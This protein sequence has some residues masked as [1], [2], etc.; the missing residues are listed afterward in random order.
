MTTPKTKFASLA[1][2]AGHEPRIIR[3]MHKRGTQSN[4]R[5]WLLL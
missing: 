2:I 1:L 3:K 5:R 4:S